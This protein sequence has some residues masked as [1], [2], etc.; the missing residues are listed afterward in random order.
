MSGCMSG[1]KSQRPMPPDILNATASF[2]A[3]A[4]LGGPPTPA[5]PTDLEPSNQTDA[6]AIQFTLHDML[7]AEGYGPTVGHKIGCTTPVMQE[8]LRIDHPCAGEIFASTVH[9]EQA[10]IGLAD[11]HHIG[12]E[13][14]IAAILGRDLPGA[15]MPYDRTSVT[16]SVE[17]LTGAIELV[18]DRYEDYSALSA[19]T[20]IADDFFNAGVVLGRP[21]PEFRDL[22]LAAVRGTVHIDGEPAG[23]GVGSD[24]LGHPLDALAW[25]ANHRI[26]LGRPLRA[27]EFVMLGSVV[28]TIFLDHACT[29]TIELEG[30]G[31]AAVVFE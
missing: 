9:H 28:K 24:I 2:L 6:Y 12:V 10:R 20:L 23:S 7:T 19:P 26:A 13:C 14:E 3:R 8:F 16:P 18:D 25:L 27:G 15:E 11:H 31:S 17:A 4:R 22:D 30:L 21:N 5:P 29:I 1:R